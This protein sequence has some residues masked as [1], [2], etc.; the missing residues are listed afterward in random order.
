MQN[1]IFKINWATIG[2]SVLTA[3]VAAVVVALV[4]VV[5][6]TGFNVFGADWVSIGKNMINL[7]VIAG[8]VTFGKDFL[9]TNS[10]SL[11]AIGPAQQP[12]G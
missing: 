1:G 3:V 5:T 2:D 10:G 6:T 9:S 8:V 12:L 4:Q 7:G 11:L